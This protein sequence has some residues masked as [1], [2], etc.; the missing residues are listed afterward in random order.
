MIRDSSGAG[1]TRWLG[2]A[3]A[4]P[5]L[6][7]GHPLPHSVAI[8]NGV[9]ALGGSRNAG[10]PT[11]CD[12]RYHSIRTLGGFGSSVTLSARCR[13]W[14]SR[15]SCS[16]HAPHCLVRCGNDLARACYL[17]GCSCLPK[18]VPMPLLQAANQRKS[19]RFS[20]A[21]GQSPLKLVIVLK[22]VQGSVNLI[23]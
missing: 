15:G 2:K 22:R 11:G 7:T 23:L 19:P 5:P 13:G 6:P 16:C 4:E 21:C 8:G 9:I 17:S 10:R 12:A 3:G 1:F 14:C 18:F 20:S